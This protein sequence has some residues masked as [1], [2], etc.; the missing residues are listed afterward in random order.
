VHVILDG[1]G[2]RVVD[3]HLHV[4]NVQAAGGNVGGDEQ[5]CGARLIWRRKK[6]K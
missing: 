2:K 6:D 4:G 5:G 1:Q 3:D